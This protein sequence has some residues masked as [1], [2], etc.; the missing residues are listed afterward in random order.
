LLA[1]LDI[2][3]EAGAALNG[4]PLPPPRAADGAPGDPAGK[5]APSKP[6]AVH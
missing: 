6:G 3:G 1:C 5:P 4:A 2:V